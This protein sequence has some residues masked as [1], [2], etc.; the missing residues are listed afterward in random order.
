MKANLKKILNK[1]APN[2]LSLLQTLNNRRLFKN[3]FQKVQ[4]SFKDRVYK[5]STVYVLSG[6]FKGLKYINEIVWG[7]IMPKWLGSYEF[8]LSPIIEE[9]VSTNYKTIIDVGCAEG[10]YAAGLAFRLPKVQVFAFDVD[11]ISRTQL[12]R[13]ARM[14]NLE[15]RIILGKYCSFNDIKEKAS[16]KTLLISD[17]EGYEREL[18]D[19]TKCNT[20]NCIDILVELHELSDNID[21][22]KLIYNRFKDTH[23]I[24]EVTATDREE[25]IKNFLNNTSRLELNSQLLKEVSDEGRSYKQSWF[26]MKTKSSQIL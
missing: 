13:L 24:E 8:E 17:I 22:K 25:W 18:L 19:P 6:P 7:P 10:Y 1:V 20:L 14:N 11:Y 15:D 2:F 9:I 21:T 4:E 16:G 5:Q 23:I 26:W 3:R 12:H